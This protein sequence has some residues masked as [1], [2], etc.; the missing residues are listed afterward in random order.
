MRRGGLV[1]AT[2]AHVVFPILEGGAGK[3]CVFIGK[4]RFVLQ[5][6]RRGGLLRGEKSTPVAGQDMRFSKIWRPE[7]LF[8]VQPRGFPT[9]LHAPVWHASAEWW[10]VFAVKVIVFSVKNF[11][12]LRYSF[13]DS[14]CL[15]RFK[16]TR[17]RRA[18]R[19]SR[20]ESRYGLPFVGHRRG[21]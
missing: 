11:L 21:S 9:A 17:Y 15:P 6:H 18:D 13:F 12:F 8:R 7:V 16:P 19:G 2:A 10:W 20:L 3:K 4:F 1:W 14:C 5:D